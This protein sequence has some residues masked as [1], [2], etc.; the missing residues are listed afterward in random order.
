VPSASDNS[1]GASSGRG[2]AEHHLLEAAVLE[3]GAE[4]RVE[5]EQAGE[6]G[7]DP[8]HARRD[9]RQHGRV[10]AEREREQGDDHQRE[11]HRLHRVAATTPE[12]SEVAV[13][14]AA[15]GAQ[16]AHLPSSSVRSG[17]GGAA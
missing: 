16:R 17:T 2:R 5:V 15:G 4:Q 1:S 7:R 3:V 8:Q 14:L 13:Q 12:Q 11:Q 6:Q 10:R 9:A